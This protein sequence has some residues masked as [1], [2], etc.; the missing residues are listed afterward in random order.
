ME[1]QMKILNINDFF[2]SESRRFFLDDLSRMADYARREC[3]EESAEIIQTADQVVNQTFLFQLRWDMERTY[4]PVVFDGEINWLHQPADDPE[5]IY[6]FNRQRFW[7][8]LGQAYALTGNEVYAKTFANQLSHWV[9]TVPFDK[10]S[11]AWRTIEAGLRCEYWLKALQYFRN[12]PEMTLEFLEIFHQSMIDH[13]EYLMEVY[14]SFRLM[15]NWGILQN[16]GLFMA[17]IMLPRSTRTEEYWKTALDRLY[18]QARVQIYRDGSHWEQSPMY[19]N[20]VAHCLLDVVILAQRNHIALPDDFSQSVRNMCRVNLIGK[21]PNHREIMQ[22][23]SDDID[24][25]DIVSKGALIFR[26]PYLKF[27]GYETYDFDTLWDLGIDSLEDYLAIR[28]Q[29]PE[30]LGHGLEDSGNYYFRSTWNDKA[31][32]LHFHCGTLGAGH[33]HSDKLHIDLFSQGEDILVDAGRYTYVDK[34]DRYLFKD[35]HA[36]NTMTVDGK[37]FTVCTDPWGCSKLSQP[38]NQHWYNDSRYGFVQGGHL[39]YTDLQPDGVFVNRKI[40]YIRPDMYLICDEFYTSGAHSYQQFF[41]FN[42]DGTLQLGNPLVYQGNHAHAEVQFLTPGISVSVMDSYISR[43]YNRREPNPAVKIEYQAQG[44][45]S[46]ITVISTNPAKA[47]EP[48]K[49]QK[50]P[51][52]STFKGITFQDDQVEAVHLQKGDREFVVIIGHQ[53]VASPTDMVEAYGC[54]GFG[55]VIV[56]D[57]TAGERRLGTVLCW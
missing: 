9:K 36:H 45:S 38:V 23:D 37:D 32:F 25:R 47:T 35:P 3:Q 50:V 5:W 53:E 15:S 48:I 29:E 20:E 46:L 8:C 7:I 56:F 51:V 16:H 40:V 30:D 11:P 55:N 6:A 52:R 14:D 28:S 54:I 4:E 43:H 13:A 17:G 1:D 26:D 33:G 18:E 10:T 49:T 41:H 24:V 12:S 21:K 44:I 22:G 19:H 34:P 27:G 39:G 2:S 31:D 57:V 42:N